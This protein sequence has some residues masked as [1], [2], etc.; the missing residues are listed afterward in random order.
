MIALGI[1]DGCSLA[2][3]LAFRLP[4]AYLNREFGSFT[5]LVTRRRQAAG[6]EIRALWTLAGRDAVR[7][8]EIC[9]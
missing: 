4:P 5:S 8:G 7:A 9:F 3:P 2:S 6:G 1:G